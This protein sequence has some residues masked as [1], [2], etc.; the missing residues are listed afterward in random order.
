MKSVYWA[1]GAPCPPKAS[2]APVVRRLRNASSALFIK[3][4]STCEEFAHHGWQQSGCAAC[5][6]SSI[7]RGHSPHERC[8]ENNDV[9]LNS[10][11]ALFILFSFHA[12][13]ESSSS[14][15]SPSPPCRPVCVI[16]FCLM[17]TSATRVGLC[18]IV[19]NETQLGLLVTSWVSAPHPTPPPQKMK[20]KGGWSCTPRNGSFHTPKIGVCHR[21]RRSQEAAGSRS[22]RRR[23]PGE[24]SRPA[25]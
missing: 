14:H 18:R 4:N 1:D 13:M 9:G 15:W 8:T 21:Q 16:L 22:E 12:A 3:I 17:E 19:H 7:P 6:S 10:H 5:P 20:R 23:G 11:G 25:N 2:S 24:A